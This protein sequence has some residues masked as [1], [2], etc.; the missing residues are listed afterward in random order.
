MPS[1]DSD[2]SGYP[3]RLEL[4]G[5]TLRVQIGYDPEFQLGV[6]NRPN[7]PE[8]MYPA[9]VD[10]GATVSCIDSGLAVRLRLPIVDQYEVHGVHGPSEV[11]VHLAQI[12][13]PSLDWTISKPLAAGNLYSDRNPL[14]ALIGRDF[15]RNFIMI[16]NGI[17]GSVIIRDSTG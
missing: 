14:F 13:V 15:L 6:Q 8:E 12:Y 4:Q 5:P 2:F 11:N 9:L 10:T 1:V 17:T 16:Y 3:N 7:L